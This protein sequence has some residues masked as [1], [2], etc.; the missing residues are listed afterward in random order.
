[1]HPPEQITCVFSGTTITASLVG[2]CCPS[3]EPPRDCWLP[4]AG[5]DCPGWVL[6][7]DEVSQVVISHAL[8]LLLLRQEL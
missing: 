8:S 6:G 4:A 2:L 5:K 7:C 3:Q 1:M